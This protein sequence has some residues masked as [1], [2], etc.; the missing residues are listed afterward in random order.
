MEVVWSLLIGGAAGWLAGL[1]MKGKGFG[2]LGNIIIGIIGGILGGFL[3]GQLGI[4]IGGGE[5]VGP[6]VMSLVGA[7][8]ILF[9]AGLI[10]KGK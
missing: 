4:E 6:L 2:I 9:L 5:F 3:F 8:V 10:R 7:V 1:I